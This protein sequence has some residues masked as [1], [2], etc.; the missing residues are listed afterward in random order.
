MRDGGVERGSTHNHRASMTIAM[1]IPPP[2][3]NPATP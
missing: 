1:P 3:H 2:M